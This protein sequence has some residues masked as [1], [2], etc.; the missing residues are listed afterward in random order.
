MGI[1]CIVFNCSDQLDFLSMGRFFRGMA[2]C[3]A[4]ACFGE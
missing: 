1:Q 4:W 3:G 2:M